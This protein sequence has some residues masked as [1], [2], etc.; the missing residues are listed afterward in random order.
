M[1][2]EKLLINA[3]NLYGVDY[4]DLTSTSRKYNLQYLRYAL[5][6]ELFFSGLQSD[7]IGKLFKRDR[8][9][10]TCALKVYRDL[11]KYPPEQFIKAIEIVKIITNK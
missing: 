2:V 7:Q 5:Y 1:E 11:M 9:T 4:N 3:A 6:Y 10:I 8:T